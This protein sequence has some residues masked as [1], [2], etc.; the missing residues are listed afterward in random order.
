MNT[1]ENMSME[2][3]HV[4]SAL[5]PPEACFFP[6][7]PSAA[8]DMKAVWHDIGSHAPLEYWN[9]S[10]PEAVLLPRGYV[11]VRRDLLVCHNWV[12]TDGQG[13]RLLLRVQECIA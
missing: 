12:G 3:T 7:I 1:N 9:M 10:Q 13:L 5:C 4:S 2:D 6:L 8:W 11:V